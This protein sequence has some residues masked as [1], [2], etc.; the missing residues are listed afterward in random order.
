MVP[1]QVRD[2]VPRV[3]EDLLDAGV[4]QEGPQGG[5]VPDRGGIDEE[6]PAVRVRDLQEAEADVVPDE[7]VRLGVQ[8]EG[9]DSRERTDQVA[10]VFPGADPADGMSD[11]TGG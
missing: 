2:V 7:V 10:Q 6:D 4:L 11:G 9:G 1:L 8:R 3:M 5:E